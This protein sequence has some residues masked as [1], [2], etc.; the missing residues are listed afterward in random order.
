VRH[1]APDRIDRV[2]PV[3]PWFGVCQDYNQAGLGGPQRLLELAGPAACGG[4]PLLAPGELTSGER[5]HP[6][7][8]RLEMDRDIP[9]EERERKCRSDRESDG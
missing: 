1:C 6:V 4:E 3:S 7:T 9:I 5:G 8:P 2:A